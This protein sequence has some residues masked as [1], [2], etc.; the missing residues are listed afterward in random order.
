M[1]H[2]IA[3]PRTYMRTHTPTIYP[4]HYDEKMRLRV[5]N[6]DNPSTLIERQDDE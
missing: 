1:A 3:L 5:E 2:A 4:A 6:A